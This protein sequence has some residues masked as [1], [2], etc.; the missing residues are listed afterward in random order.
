MDPRSLSIDGL[1]NLW[2]GTSSEG[3]IKFDGTTCTSYTTSNSGLP[4]DMIYDLGVDSTNR[5]WIST[6]NGVVNFDGA[7]WAAPITDCNSPL[8][9]NAIIKV[10]VDKDNS[11]WFGSRE[12]LT[13][14]GIQTSTEISKQDNLIKASL[15]I[16]PNPFSRATTVQ[17]NTVLVDASICIYNAFGQIVKQVNNVSGKEIN[18]YVDNLSSGVYFLRLTQNNKILGA[19][20]LVL[21]ND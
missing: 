2:I 4:H 7:N 6:A 11:V 16:Y 8:S 14:Y 21:A 12:G 3:L 1:G 17:F 10:F 13:R 19:E 18:L 5:V 9:N 15:F 20:K